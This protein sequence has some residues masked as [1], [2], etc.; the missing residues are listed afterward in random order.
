[1]SVSFE[2]V[3]QICATFLGSGLT[4]GKVVKL[5]QNGTAAPCKTDDPFCGVV[6]HCGDGACTVQV[7]GFVS[8]PYSGTAPT[9]GWCAL[10]ADGQGGVKTA[11]SGGMKLLVV[12][13][14][15]TAKTVTVML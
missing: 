4:E 6:L 3:G 12:D 13:V 9:V 15:A 1:M 10:A 5:S 14:D 7:R 2:G 8:V 11:A